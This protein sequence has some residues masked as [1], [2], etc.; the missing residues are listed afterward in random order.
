MERRTILTIAAI[1]LASHL[2]AASSPGDV[3]LVGDN[4]EECTIGVANGVVTADGRPLLW[5]VRDIGQEAARQQ[6]VYISGSPYSYIGVC[7]EGDGIY[8]GLN[9][10]G[11]ASGNSLVRPIPGTAPNSSVQSTI[12]RSFATVDQTRD[13]FSSSAQAGTCQ[14]SGCFPFIDALGNAVILEV[15]RSV[16]IWDYDS[17]DLDRQM[18]GLYGFV[19]RANEFHMRS[20]GSDDIG[21]GGRYASGVYN[22]LGLIADG[23]LSVRGLIQGAGDAEGYHEFIRYGPGRAL[24]TIARDTTQSAVIVHGVLP[25]EDPALATM[26]VL[27]GQTNYSIAVPT[28]A[29]VSKVPECLRDGLMYDRARSLWVKGEEEATQASVFPLEAHLLDVVE[30]TLLPHWRSYGVPDVPEMTRIEARMA[31]DAYSLLDCLDNRRNDNQPPMVSLD[32]SRDGLTATF[33][34][35]TDD[36]DG[37]VVATVWDFGD[38]CYSADA[39]PSHVYDEP[40]AYLVS[41]TATD[42]YGVSVTGWQYH[43]I[44]AAADVPDANEPRFMP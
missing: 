2:A 25:D 33:S 24:A 16:Q 18:Q 38:D 30:E 4:S 44:H 34:V 27:L 21:I 3:A 43:E 41:C 20:D 10:A 14:A 12:L 5:K 32:V 19:V 40:G 9:E 13:Y 28:W 23:S 26:W 7:T 29:R 1:L 31:D 36:P 15:N 6:L 11:V 39:A 42:D 8:M 17:L 35:T 37:V 22:V